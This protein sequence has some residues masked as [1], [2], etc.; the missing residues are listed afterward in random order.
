[1]SKKEYVKYLSKLIEQTCELESKVRKN[2]AILS[3]I[4]EKLDFD[5][6]G[7]VLATEWNS[8]LEALDYEI[9][10]REFEDLDL[11]ML[12]PLLKALENTLND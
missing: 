12:K 9:D 10:S 7:D 4:Y 11:G 6:C 8:R 1:M 3:D 5:D 2:R